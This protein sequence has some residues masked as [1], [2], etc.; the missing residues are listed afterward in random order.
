MLSEKDYKRYKKEL[1]QEKEKLIDQLNCDKEK[2][3]DFFKEDHHVGD[4]IDKANN[5]FQK[6]TTISITEQEKKKLTAIEQALLR[7]E[8]K[9]YGI[10]LKCGKQ[11]TKKRLSVVP[12]ASLCISNQCAKG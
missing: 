7:I 3:K 6:R 2:V 1:L 5:L 9:N 12:W 4:I 10:C 8:K 11:I